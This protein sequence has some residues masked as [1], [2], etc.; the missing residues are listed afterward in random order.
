MRAGQNNGGSVGEGTAGTCMVPPGWDL[1]DKLWSKSEY[2][3]PA[4]RAFRRRDF[5]GSNQGRHA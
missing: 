1:A 3:N 4:R 5:A 2:L